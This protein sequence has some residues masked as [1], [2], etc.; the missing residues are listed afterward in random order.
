MTLH[1]PRVLV[2]TC[3]WIEW[4]TDGVLASHFEPYLADPA[5]L[6]VPS[7]LQF[8]LYRW[9]RR[10][11]GESLAL[12]II[13]ITHQGQLMGIDARLAIL[14]ADLALQ[15]RLAMADALI[16]ACAQSAGCELIS[17]DR[18]F[19]GLPGVVHFQKR[20]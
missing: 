6:V 15:Y 10:E 19:C 18:H 7:I 14:A 13:A 1:E 11:R 5:H 12:Q 16:Y 8:E 4:L 17:S 9:I 3:G 20:A 2:D